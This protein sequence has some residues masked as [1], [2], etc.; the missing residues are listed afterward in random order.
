MNRSTMRSFSFGLFLATSFFASFYYFIETDAEVEQKNEQYATLTKEEMITSLEQEGYFILTEAEKK[1]IE[2]ESAKDSNA[3]TTRAI[4]HI[5]EGM[6]SDEVIQQLARLQMIEDEEAFQTM[7]AEKNASTMLQT[8][9]Y[10]LHS[11]M[12]MEKIIET[13]TNK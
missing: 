1:A 13:I 4:L 9:Y 8:G 12:D 6:S 5:E 11:E 10:E 2:E 7:L 3:S